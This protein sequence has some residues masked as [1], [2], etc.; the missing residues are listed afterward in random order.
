[1][2]RIALALAAATL[3]GGQA[4]AG[5]VAVFASTPELVRVCRVLDRVHKMPKGERPHDAA[6]IYDTS[7]DMEACMNYLWGYVAGAGLGGRS[8]EQLICFP[9]HATA[10]QLAAVFLQW[11]NANPQSWDRSPADTVFT[12]FA[13]AWPCQVTGATK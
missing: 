2:M 8:Q 7:S 4:R 3:L 1:M 5:E 13:K 6:A 9:D 11:A 12:A 10:Q